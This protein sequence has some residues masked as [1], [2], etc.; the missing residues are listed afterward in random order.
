MA[1]R[2][3]RLVVGGSA[4][5]AGSSVLAALD[6]ATGSITWQAP[7]PALLTIDTVAFDAAGDLWAGG[8]SDNFAA[9]DN[10]CSTSLRSTPEA[11]RSPRRRSA[12]WT[13]RH[14]AAPSRTA[15]RSGA[16]GRA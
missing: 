6:P 10:R 9:P 2:D 14:K 12:A 7:T 1:M 13:S 4:G 3:G 15:S 8:T 5:W 11:G 16:A